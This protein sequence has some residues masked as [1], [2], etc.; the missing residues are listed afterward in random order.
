MSLFVV[1]NDVGLASD[2]LNSA[3]EDLEDVH[4][5]GEIMSSL[6]NAQDRLTQAMAHIEDLKHKYGE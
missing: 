5:D 4:I 1:G 6:Y 2:H 3:I